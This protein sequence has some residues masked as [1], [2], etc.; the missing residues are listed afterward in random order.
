MAGFTF[1]GKDCKT[2]L[3]KWR[4]KSTWLL[5][6]EISTFCGSLRPPSSSVFVPLVV[7]HGLLDT[8][9]RSLFFYVFVPLYDFVFVFV[10]FCDFPLAV[11]HGLLIS[12]LT[13]YQGPYLFV[14]MC[15]CCLSWS[16]YFDIDTMSRSLFVCVCLCICV[17]CV[18]VCV[19]VMTW[20]CFQGLKYREGC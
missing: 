17:F 19:C 1:I 5:L 20:I 9:S 16:S 11:S 3:W 14:H 13:Q 15:D 18:C 7:F 10:C 4:N 12:V 2:N 8:I 6:L